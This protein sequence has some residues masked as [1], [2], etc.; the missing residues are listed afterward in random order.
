VKRLFFVPVLVLAAATAAAQEPAQSP[1]PE[2][3]TGPKLNLKL[4]EPAR[5]SP[6]ITFE[7]KEGASEKRPAESLPELGGRPSP[8][9]ERPLSPGA[10]AS[11]F[12]ED[13]NPGR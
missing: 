6:R 12:P 2:A 10:R 4:E 8:A 1:Q 9:L 3:K 13:T 5:S 7:P 11:P